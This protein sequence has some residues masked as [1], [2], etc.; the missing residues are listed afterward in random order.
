MTKN[1]FDQFCTIW[2]AAA[3]MYNQTPSDGTVGFLFQA[4]INYDIRE[5]SAALAAHSLDPE[6]GRFAPKPADIVRHIQG[7]GQSN[8]LIA[9]TKAHDAIGSAGPYNSVVFDDPKIMA[10]IEDM[11]GWIEF[12]A[13][14]EDDRP[15]KQNEFAKRYQG[16]TI[17][18]PHRHPPK[19]LGLAEAQNMVNCPD[20]IEPPLLIGDKAK[21]L[22]VLEGGEAKRSGLVAL[23][24]T[25]SIGYGGD[26][27]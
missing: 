22:A 15:Y 11:G 17:K 2:T 26:N 23:G 4:L 7:D 9:W 8:A 5:I 12:N 20:D 10:V 21:A 6:N 16:Y 13:I 14:T 18:P 1:D 3:G 25:R 24:L 19:L 27:E